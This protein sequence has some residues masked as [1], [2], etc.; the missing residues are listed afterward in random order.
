MGMAIT[1]E[2]KE[3]GK[4]LSNLEAKEKNFS[5]GSTGY[6]ANGIIVIKGKAL[7]CNFLFIEIGS[8]KKV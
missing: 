8:K 1:I 2:V 5:T 3:D 4:V 6:Y 7:R